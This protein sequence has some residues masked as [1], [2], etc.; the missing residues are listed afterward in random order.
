MRRPDDEVI[1]HLDRRL[2]IA[3]TSPSCTS[4]VATATPEQYVFSFTRGA[5]GLDR[6]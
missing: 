5:L 2:R 4:V 3:V 1:A 6:I